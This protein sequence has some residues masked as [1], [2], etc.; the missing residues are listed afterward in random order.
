MKEEEVVVGLEEGATTVEG[1]GWVG[2]AAEGASKLKSLFLWMLLKI[3]ERESCL[4]SWHTQSCYL[5]L[6][7]A[8]VVPF[9]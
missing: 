8:I 1:D 9:C 4:V 2:L 6:I 5:Y 3:R 7:L